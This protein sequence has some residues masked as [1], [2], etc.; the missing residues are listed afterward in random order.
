VDGR[1]DAPKRDFNRQKQMFDGHS[2]TH[3][4]PQAET[5]CGSLAIT[6]GLSNK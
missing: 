3:R 5:A 2:S 4:L 1:R 6:K